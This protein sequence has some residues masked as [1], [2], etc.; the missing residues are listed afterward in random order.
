[1]NLTLEKNSKKELTL[2]LTF[3]YVNLLLNIFIAKGL[4]KNKRD[5]VLHLMELKVDLKI[6]TSR[7]EIPIKKLMSSAQETLSDYTPGKI[8]QID[9][10]G[11]KT[12]L[13]KISNFDWDGIRL[14]SKY[15]KKSY[16]TL[17]IYNKTIEMDQDSEKSEYDELTV[18]PYLIRFE[19]RLH[20]EKLLSLSELSEKEKEREMMMII[21][22][23]TSYLRSK[24]K[25]YSNK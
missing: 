6:S 1:M 8:K 15:N 19:I 9:L 18:Y 4:L 17:N 23:F 25:N 7:K 16:M 3:H 24:D 20:F 11:Y 2:S 13:K 5:V 21:Q 12:N 10:V 14:T 22:V